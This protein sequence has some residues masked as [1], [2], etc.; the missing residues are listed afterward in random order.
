MGV[1]IALFV[2][3][4]ATLGL[5]AAAA[6]GTGAP[7]PSSADVATPRP[8]PA[9]TPV[10][11]PEPTP[12]PLPPP[13]PT[14]TPSPT[15]EPTPP[16]V[17]APLTGRLVAPSVA[18][19]HPIAVMIDDLS[20]ARPQS[21]LHLASVVWHAPAE[22]GI[23]RYMAIFQ[24]GLPTEI[25]PVRSARSYYI[26]W[27][28][29]WRAVYVH[30]GGSP[31]AL[32]T[33]RAKGHGQ[34]VYN[35]DHFRY[36]R[37]HFRRTRNRFAPHNVY[38]D[39]KTLRKLGKLV[40]AK[41]KLLKPAWRFAPDAR[42]ADRPVGGTIRVSYRANTITYKYHRASNTYR[43]SVTGEGKQH[44]AADGER[45]APKNVVVMV[46][47]FIATGDSKHRLEGDVLG[48]GKAFIS[49][50][51]RT[52]EGTWKKASM[53]KPT[54]FYDEDGN[55]VTLTIGQT[56]IQVMPRGAPIHIEDGEDA[57]PEPPP[58][59]TAPPELGQTTR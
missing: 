50:N 31:Q 34:Y 48:S 47:T 40:G 29:E 16:P 17:A 44:D 56:F 22:G 15:P 25:G 51:G 37:T 45:I 35:A 58:A 57:P 55:P 41:D 4:V 42:L 11:T 49:T 36:G 7:T 30:S 14:A 9:P 19:R 2:A 27:A 38:T 1:A 8:T 46:M 39:G 54:R 33:L 13:V 5:V 6:V 28:A 43:R 32:A 24:D 21:G 59:A 20:P 23:P 18:K 26:A 52:I 53:T 12:A 3:G 10:P